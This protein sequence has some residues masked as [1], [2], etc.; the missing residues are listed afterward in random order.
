L[1]A[2]D[3]HAFV[4][5][6]SVIDTIDLEVRF[7]NIPNIDIIDWTPRTISTRPIER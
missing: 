4:L 3:I 5:D 7:I 2:S 1:T 6:D